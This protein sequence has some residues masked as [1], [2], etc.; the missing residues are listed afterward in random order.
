MAKKEI[1]ICLDVEVAP[2]GDEMALTKMW[3]NG[4]RMRVCFL[5]GDPE[6][7]EKVKS[8]A[9][10]W[11]SHANITLDFV[12]DPQAEIRITFIQ[13]GTSWSA[14]G[15]DALNR[16][17]FPE[18][19]S[20]M[21]FGWLTRDSDEDEYSRV[22]L[23]EFGHAL[24]C[25]HEHQNPAGGIPWNHEAVYRYYA[26]RNWSKQRVDQSL[27]RKYELDRKNYTAF[28]RD[29]IMLYPIPKELMDGEFEIGWNRVLSATDIQ[30][31]G[32]KYPEP[33]PE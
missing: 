30:F 15:V 7:Q 24:G 23:H 3:R 31:I 11:E 10:Q 16:E 4:T 6:V 12:D 19:A 32:E 33:Q 9:R 1:K 14:V 22:V 8:Y 20:T 26:A 25:I 5:G 18:E 29:S 2:R 13:D 28:D 17:Y 21:N 27:F